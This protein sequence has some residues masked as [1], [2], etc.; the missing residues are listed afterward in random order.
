MNLSDVIDQIYDKKQARSDLAKQDKEL[1]QDLAKLE[2]ELLQ[3]MQEAG[4]FTASSISGHKATVKLN[5]HPTVTDW[6]A[7]YGFIAETKNFEFLQKRLSAPSFRE[8]WAENEVIPGTSVVEIPEI[9][10][11]KSRT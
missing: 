5:K 10:F 2:A 8:R 6:P 1:S 11:T 7:F 3:R 4:T 9:S